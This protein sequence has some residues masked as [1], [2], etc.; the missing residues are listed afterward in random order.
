[1]KKAFWSNQAVCTHIIWPAFVEFSE[2]KY[3]E[4]PKIDIIVINQVIQENQG[5]TVQDHQWVNG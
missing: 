2:I 5:E 1:M 3:P 4:L